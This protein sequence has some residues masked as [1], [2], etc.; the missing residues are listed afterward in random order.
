M[1][2]RH[3]RGGG[4]KPHGVSILPAGVG[5]GPCRISIQL[6]LMETA[7]VALPASRANRE[8]EATRVAC[9][10]ESLCGISSAPFQKGTGESLCGVSTAPRK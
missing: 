3:D 6:R 5:S 10:R 7:H 2:A 8:W 4:Q 1:F 9:N